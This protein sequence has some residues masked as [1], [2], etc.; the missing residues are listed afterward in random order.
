[1]TSINK[2]KLNEVERKKTVKPPK[3]LTTRA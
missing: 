1:M 2:T 3:T